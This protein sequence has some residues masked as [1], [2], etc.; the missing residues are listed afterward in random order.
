MI[1]AHLVNDANNMKKKITATNPSISS[2]VWK[3]MVI[4]DRSKI[5]FDTSTYFCRSMHYM[6]SNRE[7]TELLWPFPWYIVN[8]INVH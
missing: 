3:E 5:F 1:G 4:N 2:T 6:D 7:Q 8:W